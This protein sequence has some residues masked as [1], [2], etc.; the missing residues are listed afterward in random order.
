M[1]TTASRVLA[2]VALPLALACGGSDGGGGNQGGSGGSSGGSGGSSGGSGGSAGGSGGSSGG[3]GGSAAG[4]GGSAA[5]SGGSAAGAGGGMAGAGGAGGMMGS[6]DAGMPGT[7]TACGT[8][9]TA[10]NGTV[11]DNFD[12]MS[13][14]LEWRTA[15][16]T[17]LAG[18]VVMPMGSLNVPVTGKETLAL[19]ALA[20]W[21]AL[22]RPCMDASAYT[23]I[24]FTAM[25]NVTNLLFRIATP[26]TYPTSEGGICTTPDCAYAHWQ[27]D[28]TAGL[29]G[30]ATIQVSFAELTAP[31]GKPLPFDKSALNALVFL[32]TDED[33]THS[34]TIDNVSFY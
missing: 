3:S 7:P 18:T 1:K 2:L 31:F 6:G 19:G 11:I 28:V 27:K 5:G 33:A 12:G 32:T 22:S 9:K 16:A 25:G 17:N 15:D 30:G 13:Q 24:Q 21:A 34:F 26:G 8:G 14:V 20:S 29:A 23:G 4:A 10:P